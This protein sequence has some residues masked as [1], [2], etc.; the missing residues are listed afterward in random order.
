MLFSGQ[1]LTIITPA[2]REGM[3]LHLSVTGGDVSQHVMGVYA[4]LGRT[5]RTHT[6]P[7]WADNPLDTGPQTKLREGMFLHLSVTGGRCIPACNGGVRPS[8]P[9]QTPPDTCTPSLGRQPSRTQARKRSCGKVCFYTCLS[10][11]E[12]YP[13]MQWGCTP[14]PLDTYTPSLGRQ[15][16]WTHPPGRHPQ[17][18]HTNTSWADTP[19][20]RHSP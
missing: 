3:F 7:P 9:G 19:L 12:M 15:P 2:K 16:P 5:P 11:G 13:S 10:R 17:D 1:I 4:P 14:P 6:H 8:P 20:G 18:T